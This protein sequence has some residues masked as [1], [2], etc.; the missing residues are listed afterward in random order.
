QHHE[1]RCGPGSAERHEPA[2][3]PVLRCRR[4]APVPASTTIVGTLPLLIRFHV[5]VCLVLALGSR[6]WALNPSLDIR[7]YAHTSCKVRDGFVTGIIN[8][9][10]Q[11]PDGY[12]W[13]GTDDGL[14]RFDGVK[15]VRWQPRVAGVGGLTR[16]RGL[17]GARDGT[18]W[19][20]TGSGIT[21]L[22]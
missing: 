5:A 10:A 15:T 19:I 3:Q 1:P 8:A 20:D 12:L 4:H 11:T 2:V 16:V 14:F 22:K 6:A 18:L 13:I 9:I 21:R 17:R 7:Q